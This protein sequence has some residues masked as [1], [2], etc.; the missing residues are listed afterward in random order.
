MDQ[1]QMWMNPDVALVIHNSAPDAYREAAEIVERDFDVLLIEHEFGLFG[2]KYGD[3]LMLLMERI[4]VPIIMTCHTVPDDH[5]E[6]YYTSVFQKM[7]PFID[8][9]TVFLPQLCNSDFFKGPS[10]GPPMRCLFQSHGVV[11]RPNYQGFDES[12]GTDLALLTEQR[13]ALRKTM[14]G[15]YGI[16]GDEY[17]ILITP[18]LISPAKGVEHMV[19]AMQTIVQ[20]IPNA[21]YVILGQQHPGGKEPYLKRLQQLAKDLGIEKQVIFI[22]DYQEKEDLIKFIT[23]VD[24]LVAPYLDLSQTSSGIS[25]FAMS[26][27]KVLLTTTTHFAK[28]MCAEES[29]GVGV[30]CFTVPPANS[31]ALAEAAIRVLGDEKLMAQT[32][33]NA[34]K[35]QRGALWPKVALGL[36]ESMEDIVRQKREREKHRLARIAASLEEGTHSEVD[37]GDYHHDHRP[38]DINYADVAWDST[39]AQKAIEKGIR[40]LRT[41]VPVISPNDI[42]ARLK[43][44]LTT[45]TENSNASISIDGISKYMT[46]RDEMRKEVENVHAL[47]GAFVA[48]NNQK[49]VP[50]FN[51]QP[52]FSYRHFDGTFYANNHLILLN[53]DL[54]RGSVFMTIPNDLLFGKGILFAGHFLHF[55]RGE[56]EFTERIEGAS[57]SWSGFQKKDGSI[58]L[59]FV[60][61]F[62]GPSVGKPEVITPIADVTVEFTMAPGSMVVRQRFVVMLYDPL[63]TRNVW[64]SS[65]LDSVSTAFPGVQFDFFAGR[66]DKVSPLSIYL[67]LT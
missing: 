51:K 1:G 10:G 47:A 62:S 19:T 38:G 18:G 17:K 40:V 37:E 60:K 64:L 63:N 58:V 44:G 50:H 2:G 52:F 13:R 24:L 45:L 9:V 11:Q 23:S 61:T 65:G 57:D 6:V 42:I 35:K 36:L 28:H 55:M 59:K 56:E 49:F 27:G 67:S 30:A 34:W 31:T 3:H 16:A 12:E 41:K 20:S 53:G 46:T 54:A 43:S 5:I 66:Y 32:R 25:S 4:S 26:L 29:S 22:S 7:L 8:M 21:R 48:M 39:P 14:F 15:C 33:Y